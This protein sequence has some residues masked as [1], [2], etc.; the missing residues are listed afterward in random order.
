[1]IAIRRYLVM[2]AM[3]T[4]TLIA[5]IGDAQS[6]SAQE[7]GREW[8]QYLM[9]LTEYE[10]YD[11]ILWESYYDRLCDLE[12]NPI[13]IN[14]AT[15]EDLENLPFLS[16]QDVESINEYIYK[17]G[18]MKTLGELVMISSLDYNKRKL[19]FFFTYAGDIG[20]KAFPGIGTIMKYGKNSLTASAKIPLYSRKGDKR[21]YEGY[22]YKHSIRYDFSYG[23]RVRVGLIGSQDAGEPFFAGRNSMGYDF[24]SYYLLIKKMGRIKALA[25]GR[26]RL[27]FGLGLVMNNN[28]SFGKL[29]ALSSLGSNGTDIRAH[30]SSSS[31]NYLQGVASTV[32]VA[33]G[34]D[35]TAFVSGRKIDATL[36]KADSTISSIVTSGYHRTKT[37]MAKKNNTSQT[38]YGGSVEWRRYGF[39]IGLSA[40]F[41]SLDRRLAPDRSVLYRRHYATGKSFSNFGVNYGYT[42]RRFAINGE[43]ATDNSNAIATINAL[44]FEATERLS[45]LAVQRFYSF[46]YNAIM[47]SSFSEGGAV[48]NESGIYLGATWK[49]R[50]D[51]SIMAYSDI[52]YFAWPK[53]QASD[54]SMGFDNS[55]QVVYAPSQ[56]NIQLRYR[57]KK[58]EKD[59]SDKTSLI[60][61]TEHRGRLGVGY[62]ANTWSCKTQAEMSSFCYKDKSFGWI[63]S[64]TLTAKIGKVADITADIGYFDTDD[65]NSR[66]YFYERGLSYSF[67]CPSYYGNGIRYSAVLGI[68]AIRNVTLTAKIGTSNYFDRSKIGSSYQEINHSSATDVELQ[69]RWKW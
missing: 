17:N 14:T 13:N 54:S 35:I 46:R 48:Q 4:A 44:R 18:G 29:S 33:K 42:N 67:Y 49:P 6:C 7:Q 40:V 27:K 15:R 10:E 11:N 22:K 52:A 41:T 3:L 63:V 62:T 47:A 32:N 16:S 1:M 19:L 60:Y 58:R 45:L 8:E 24:Y 36:N 34:F 39:N 21:G 31:G 59:N 56:W 20:E 5:D 37:E 55:I 43:T 51:L 66:V 65:Y 30:A 25:V 12:S 53:Y 38:A 9:Q 26:Y 61:Q 2:M 23:D 68:K 69:M 50:T 64:Q 28:Y 57:L